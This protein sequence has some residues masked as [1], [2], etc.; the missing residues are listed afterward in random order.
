MP[1]DDS[2]PSS[3]F[4][5]PEPPTV[6]PP[7]SSQADPGLSALRLSG[8][9][10]RTGGTSTTGGEM[11]Q[12]GALSFSKGT[13]TERPAGGEIDHGA[14]WTRSRSQKAILLASLSVGPRVIETMSPDGAPLEAL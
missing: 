12:S 13:E 6:L 5:P 3:Y 14:P 11:Y 1:G 10:R 8:G 7:G 4:Q 9:R 2:S